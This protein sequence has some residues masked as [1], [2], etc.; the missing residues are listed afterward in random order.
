M[1]EFVHG[2]ELRAARTATPEC[3]GFLPE[4]AAGTATPEC[5]GFLPEMRGESERAKKA[6]ERP[7]GAEAEGPAPRAFR[8]Q[9]HWLSSS[10]GAAFGDDGKDA[11]GWVQWGLAS[12]HST[13]GAQRWLPAH[14]CSTGCR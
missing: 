1:Y 9:E 2:F 12:D 4:I 10:E 11:E 14:Q 7:L 13:R 6:S 3:S 5:S 8:R